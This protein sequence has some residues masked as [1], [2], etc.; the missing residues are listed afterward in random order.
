MQIIFPNIK[1]QN[2]NITPTKK[3]LNIE[4]KYAKKYY[5]CVLIVVQSK[6]NAM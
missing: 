6:V 5:K 2:K 3:N 4:N 1:K